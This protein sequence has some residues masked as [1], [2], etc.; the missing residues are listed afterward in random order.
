[1][2]VLG[3]RD[4][5]PICHAFFLILWCLSGFSYDVL[6]VVLPCAR[7]RFE[8]AVYTVP[9]SMETNELDLFCASLATK[10]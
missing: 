7:I 5:G 9:F 1:M 4:Y 3:F 2:E 8:T 6:S 10:Q